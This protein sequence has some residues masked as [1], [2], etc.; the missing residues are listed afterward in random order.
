M[1]TNDMT[2]QYINQ[3]TTA[4]HWIHRSR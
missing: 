4:T 1:A 3:S 2:V